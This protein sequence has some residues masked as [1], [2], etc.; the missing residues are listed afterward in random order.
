M[1]SVEDVT[2]SAFRVVSIASHLEVWIQKSE[3]YFSISVSLHNTAS[4]LMV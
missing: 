2:Q 3:N 1:F 4:H